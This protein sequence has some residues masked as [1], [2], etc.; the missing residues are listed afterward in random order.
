MLFMSFIIT[1][2]ALVTWVDEDTDISM[3][4]TL[5]EEEKE[6]KETKE[7]GTHDSDEAFEKPKHSNPNIDVF[8]IS[9]G[10][11]FFSPNFYHPY[12]PGEVAPPPEFS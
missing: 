7:K 12:C 11:V 8:E 2:T 9:V 5:V 10:D 6:N 3:V 1:P 4:F